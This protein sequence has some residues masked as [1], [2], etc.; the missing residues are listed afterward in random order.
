[1]FTKTSLKK[2][3]VWI[4][5]KKANYLAAGEQTPFPKNVFSGLQNR[6]AKTQ[7]FWHLVLPQY[8]GQLH[9]FQNKKINSTPLVGTV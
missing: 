3:E 7:S 2:Q 9:K 1:V 6:T 5:K 8:R 4:E